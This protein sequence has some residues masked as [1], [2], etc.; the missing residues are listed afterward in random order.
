MSS[1]CAW[2]SALDPG[3]HPGEVHADAWPASRRRRRRAGPRARRTRAA[4]IIDLGGG[5]QRLGRH[6]VGQH[7][8]AAQPVAVHHGHLGA[9]LGRDQRR[10]VAARPP[11]MIP[12]CASRRGILPSRRPR[13]GTPRPI[14]C[15]PW[16]STPPTA[17]TWTRGRW[18]AGARTRRSAAPAGWTAGGSRSAART[19]A[20]RAPLATLVEDPAAQVFVALYDVTEPTTPALDRWEAADLA[21]FRKVRVRV[22]TL[23]GEVLGLA[24]RARRL[25][26]RAALGA[27]PGPDRRRRRGGRRARR[28][29]RR[30]A[31][32]A[33]PLGRPWSSQRLTRPCAG[34][35]THSRLT[36]GFLQSAMSGAD[37]ADMWLMRDPRPVE[38]SV[39]ARAARLPVV[40]SWSAWCSAPPEPGPAVHPGPAARR[41]RRRSTAGSRSPRP[42]ASS[43]AGSTAS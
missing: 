9:E 6:A 25:R 43:C 40:R 38:D 29:R 30:A 3:V 4:S 10:L 42:A 8:R 41:G 31:L 12:H 16:P 1:D 11:P 26:G 2:A 21:L 27:L 20:G 24:V 39:L 22:H 32:P 14:P 23:D 36:P 5:D 18:P 15:A 13:S 7:G 37:S 28:L 33:V 35:R 19:W 17:A 34:Q